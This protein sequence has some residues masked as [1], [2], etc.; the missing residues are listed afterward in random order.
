MRSIGWRSISADI[1]IVLNSFQISFL[2]YFLFYLHLLFIIYIILLLCFHILVLE[3][4][5][6][7]D[8]LELFSLYIFQIVRKIRKICFLRFC[9]ESM[10]IA[11]EVHWL[12]ISLYLNLLSRVI[13][14]SWPIIIST[15]GQ[16]VW[17]AGENQK[18]EGEESSHEL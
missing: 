14:N 2:F 16:W 6:C 18:W 15:A 11:Q 12:L 3:S 1:W 17:R 8:K 10:L 5:L 13:W 7:F 4:N 9:P